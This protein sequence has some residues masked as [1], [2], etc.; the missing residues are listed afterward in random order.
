MVAV[1]CWAHARRKYEALNDLA[2]HLQA[3]CALSMIQQLYD[4]E[5]RARDMSDAERLALRQ[6]EA[7]PIV[8][9]FKR[10]LDERNQEELPKSPLRE[11]IHYQLSRWE[12]FVRYLE[13]GAIPI[14]NN[15]TES[16]IKGTKIGKKNW[17]YFGNEHAG[18]TAAILYSL[19]MTCRR[20]S[21]DVNAYLIDVLP[22]LAN[23]P[24]DQLDNLLPHRWI[25]SHPEA[26]VKQRVQ[27]SHAVAHRKRK[28]RAER[29]I[30]KALA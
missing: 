24:V 16:A 6:A 14:D 2:P 22:R 15:R 11:A 12:V 25:E 28:R 27:E 26:R 29:R 5:D 21:I 19:T 23:C 1:G 9:E 30:A 17:L 13:D 3:Q 7:K 18:D 10:W 8:E 20:H 4:I